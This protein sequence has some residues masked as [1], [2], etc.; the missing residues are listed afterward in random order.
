MASSDHTGPFQE[1]LKV[2][3][4][5]T[6]RRLL[7]TNGPPWENEQKS[8]LRLYNCT[9]ISYYLL[10]SCCAVTQNNQ[11]DKKCQDLHSTNESSGTQRG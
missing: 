6:S 9:N 2:A 3:S 1:K 5:R 11:R 7:E 4:G 8:R 10:K